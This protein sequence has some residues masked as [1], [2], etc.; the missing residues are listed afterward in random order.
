MIRLA[1][2]LDDPS[3]TSN[4]EIEARILESLARHGLRATFAVIPFRGEEATPLPLT[5]ERARPLREAV[6][7]GV[8]D[9]ALHGH[10]HHDNNP[11]GQ[12]SEFAGL[13]ASRQRELISSGKDLLEAIFERPIRG[14]VPPYNSFD[15]ATLAV[16]EQAGLSH[17]SSN[18][19]YAPMRHTS[20]RL[21]PLTCHLPELKA[22]IAEARRFSRLQ[23]LVVVVMH[24]YDFPGGEAPV[25]SDFAEFDALLAWI[26]E[27]KDVQIRTL[28]QLAE[29]LTSTASQRVFQHN[30]LRDHLP[31]RYRHW[32]PSLC[33]ASR[34]LWWP[35]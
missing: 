31:W 1:F 3:A 13:P 20:L 25:F 24:H 2:R 14:F 15:A 27:Q 16:L 7:Q 18:M 10:S 5:R 34:P 21:L 28:S 22:A 6:E 11:G 35:G 8:L 12:P 29:E 9:V 23:P 30:R 19:R 32:L 26:A 17:L 4:R 33:A